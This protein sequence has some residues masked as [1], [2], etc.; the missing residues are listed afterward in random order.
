MT[1]F[2]DG[3]VVSRQVEL[4]TSLCSTLER[5][6]KVELVVPAKLEKKIEA[7]FCFQ[8][9]NLTTHLIILSCFE[10]PGKSIIISLCYLGPDQKKIELSLGSRIRFIALLAKVCSDATL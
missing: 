4:K 2:F 10:Y 8:N 5:K 6:E 7:T 1:P 9:E 3:S